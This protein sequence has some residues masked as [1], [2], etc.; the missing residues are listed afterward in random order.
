MPEEGRQGALGPFAEIWWAFFAPIIELSVLQ[1]RGG[2][3]ASGTY[4]PDDY[5]EGLEHPLPFV[6]NRFP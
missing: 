3:N 4:S 2:R 6:P 1:S 5:F